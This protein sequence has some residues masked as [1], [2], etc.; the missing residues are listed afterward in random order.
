MLTYADAC[1]G[2]VTDDEEEYELVCA[3][4][5]TYA[6]ACR[7]CVT[8]DEEEYELVEE[9]FEELLSTKEEKMV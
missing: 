2:C 5:L 3:R 9:T 1:R 8:D 7:G 6:D 4:M